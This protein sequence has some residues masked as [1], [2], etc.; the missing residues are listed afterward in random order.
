MKEILLQ[1]IGD[2]FFP[3]TPEDLGRA[4]GFIEY[5]PVLGKFYGRKKPRSWKQIKWIHAIIR[6][7]A[8]N[9]EDPN[10]NTEAKAKFQVKIAI[11]YI[12]QFVTIDNVIH[13]ETRSFSYS[14]LPDV[15]EANKVFNDVKMA[16][17][18][19][20]GVDPEAL[21]ARAKEESRLI[22]KGGKP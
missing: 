13:T 7:T 9:T 19:H 1:R 12:K 6:L 8:Q 18:N 15:S 20:L 10:W 22:I 21:A 2:M 17:A 11:R 16:C 3:A 5:E 14:A 4:R